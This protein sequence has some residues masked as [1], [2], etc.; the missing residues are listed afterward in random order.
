MKSNILIF[1]TNSDVVATTGSLVPIGGIV[2]RRGCGFS[3]LGNT[4]NIAEKGYYEVIINAT[5]TASAAGNITLTAQY[6]GNDIPGAT[7]TETF[8]TADTEVRSMSI[9]AIIRVDCPCDGGVTIEVGG[10]PDA[11]FENVSVGVIRV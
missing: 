9:S 2:R 1:T 11:T 5:L 6:A 4:I 10:T 8:S 3:I 7:A